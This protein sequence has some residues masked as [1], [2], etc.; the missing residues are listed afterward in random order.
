MDIYCEYAKLS[1]GSCINLYTHLV[2]Q[3]C[4]KICNNMGLEITIGENFWETKRIIV[5]FPKLMINFYMFK[6]ASNWF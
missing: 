3:N 2:Q 6:Y 5:I 1:L 4:N